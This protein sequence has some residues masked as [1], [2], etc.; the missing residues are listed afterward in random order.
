MIGMQQETI[1]DKGEILLVAFSNTSSELLIHQA[2]DYK[3][4]ILPND[5]VRDS[6]IVIEAISDTE[7]DSVFCFGQKPVLKDKV[8]IEVTAKEGD[9]WIDTSFPYG[10]LKELLEGN[11]VKVNISHNAGTSFCNKLYYNCMKYAAQR[12]LRTKI[13]FIH[14]P[15]CQNIADRK[16]FFQKIIA[17]VEKYSLT[18]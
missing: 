14:I 12:R 15:V 8:T 11:D 16:T 17:V 7:F 10:E 2:G 18:D 5:K 13:I 6:E 4:I 3:T 1:M 9:L